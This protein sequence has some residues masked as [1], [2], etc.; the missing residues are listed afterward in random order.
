MAKK[1][2][3]KV[4]KSGSKRLQMAPNG[5][6]R[7]QMAINGSK[8]LQKCLTIKTYYKVPNIAMTIKKKSGKYGLNKPKSAKR[9]KQK[10]AKKC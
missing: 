7:L 8:W 2:Y 1:I 5:C 6:K 3:L 4:S 10:Y 9:C